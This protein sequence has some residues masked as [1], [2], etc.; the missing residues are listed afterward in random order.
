MKL[1]GISFVFVRPVEPD[2]LRSGDLRCY[3]HL[4]QRQL[5]KI[6]VDPDEGLR[7]GAW[8]NQQTSGGVLNGG[9]QIIPVMDVHDLV[10]E[11]TWNNRGDDWRAQ[12]LQNPQTLAAA[13]EKLYDFSLSLMFMTLADVYSARLCQDG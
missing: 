8:F 3:F 13:P 5:R 7:S 12:A 2:S 6:F 1:E 9:V 4:P 11:T 10:F